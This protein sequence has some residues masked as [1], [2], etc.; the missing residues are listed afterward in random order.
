MLYTIKK[1]LAPHI[2]M[3]P[4]PARPMIIVFLRFRLETVAILAHSI[5]LAITLFGGLHQRRMLQRH[6]IEMCIILA[7][8]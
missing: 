6:G 7:Q 5:F 1:V 3:H 4:I 8:V 2:G